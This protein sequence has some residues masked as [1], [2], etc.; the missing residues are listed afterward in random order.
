MK[1]LTL[2]CDISEDIFQQIPSCHSAG[3][4]T[5]MELIDSADCNNSSNQTQKASKLSLR[6]AN[7]RFDEISV[8]DAQLL[9]HRQRAPS[10]GDGEQD[11]VGI[12]VLHL[13]DGVPQSVKFHYA[14]VL[15]NIA[16]A[17][18]VYRAKTIT[19]L[20][21]LPSQLDI[22]SDLDLHNALSE[23]ERVRLS[24]LK[25]VE[26]E[27]EE[28][29]KMHT[30]D[31]MTEAAK[32]G[33]FHSI[34]LQWNSEIQSSLK[35][36]FKGYPL[37]DDQDLFAFIKSMNL[38]NNYGYP[39]MVKYVQFFIS[40]DEQQMNSTAVKSLMSNQHIPLTLCPLDSPRL[41]ILAYPLV[42]KDNI[43]AIRRVLVH[44]IPDGADPRVKMI[45][46]SAKPQFKRN[47]LSLMEAQQINFDEQL[48]LSNDD[49]YHKAEDLN[50]SL[51]EQKQDNA[52]P[53]H[54]VT[55]ESS[56]GD[57]VKDGKFM[58]VLELLRMVEE[59]IEMRVAE[60]RRENETLKL[61]KN[62]PPKP[63]QTRNPSSA[64]HQ[65]VMWS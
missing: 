58:T 48:S 8:S 35:D 28:L 44:W 46:S 1:V 65:R 13:P 30:Q 20:E 36:L 3:R 47:V 26:Q 45:Y 7:A 9:L 42:V 33:G 53:Q 50:A 2:P 16:K 19:S 23:S 11:V 57:D 52:D 14:S 63:R 62:L 24:A 6:Y 17:F 41:I 15:P 27:R 4:I 21:D 37:E 10:S 25:A 38:V 64:L 51:G 12:L 34:D 18:G 43:A 5:V 32:S 31:K 54:E 60:R 22:P 39:R 59:S 40:G 49:L 55:L 29:I 61:K 56:G